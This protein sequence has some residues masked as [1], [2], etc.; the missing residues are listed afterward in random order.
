[1]SRYTVM[2]ET[3]MTEATSATVSKRVTDRS[4]DS[5]PSGFPRGIDLG[6]FFL[7]DGAGY[8]GRPPCRETLDPFAQKPEQICV[9]NGRPSV[10][11]HDGPDRKSSGP[12]EDQPRIVRV[13]DR[14][15]VH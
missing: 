8:V 6:P 1:M 14:D 4:E 10:G 13:D 5:A 11:A 2:R 9:I 7:S 3:R 12:R 15:R